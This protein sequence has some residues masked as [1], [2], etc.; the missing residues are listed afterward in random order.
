M[1]Y[2]KLFKWWQSKRIMNVQARQIYDLPGVVS[3]FVVFVVC[4]VVVSGD[5]AGVVIVVFINEVV[6]AASV[7]VVATK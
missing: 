1:R 7:E 4:C 2:M 5:V 3:R 6:V